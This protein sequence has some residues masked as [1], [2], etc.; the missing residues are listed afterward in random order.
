MGGSMGVWV[1]E[2]VDAG[3]LGGGGMAA[4]LGGCMAGGWLGGWVAGWPSGL[5]AAW[6]TGTARA[7][8]V[9]VRYCLLCALRARRALWAWPGPPRPR[10]RLAQVGLSYVQIFVTCFLMLKTGLA[11]TGPLAYSGRH[12]RME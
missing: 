5:L 10:P 6:P 2:W 12:Q 4:W 7:H 9:H 3:L 8:R 1:D 11:Q